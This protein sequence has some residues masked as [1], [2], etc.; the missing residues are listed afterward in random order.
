MGALACDERKPK[1]SRCVDRNLTCEYPKS[2]RSR[3]SGSSPSQSDSF[4]SRLQSLTVPSP[5]YAHSNY[6]STSSISPCI[7]P[8]PP[9]LDLDLDLDLDLLQA[10]SQ[11]AST[12]NAVELELLS[13]YLTHTARA[14]AFDKQD[15]Y[16]LQVGFP[17]LAFRSKPV[18]S[19]ILALA[20][21]CKCHDMIMQPATRYQ[22]K[23]QIR[24]LLALADQHH[25][26][27]LRQ[28]QAEIPYADSYDHVVANAPLMVLY[29]SASHGVRIRLSRMAAE[30][31]G[32][33]TDFALTQSQWMSLIRAAHLA[34][35]G[36]RN[37]QKG[38][39]ITLEP[40]ESPLITSI[41]SNNDH[42]VDVRDPLGED[43]P[44]PQTKRLLLPI[45]SATSSSAL[46]K[47]RSRV[48]MIEAIEDMSFSSS[49]GTFDEFMGEAQP[50]SPDIRACLDA[51]EALSNIMDDVFS[52]GRR[53]SSPITDPCSPDSNFPPS[54]QLSQVSPWLR[55][56]LARVTFATPPKPWRR[57][58][59]WFLNQAPA[60]FLDL[61]QGTLDHI[62]SSTGNQ[63]LEGVYGE[64]Q[65]FSVV[66][67]VAMDI[68][69]HWLV[70]V[71]LLDGVWW[72]DE[73]GVWELG[74]TVDFMSSPRWHD[75]IG[76]KEEGWWPRSMYNIAK[77]IKIH[78]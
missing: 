37:S 11:Q 56:Y 66:H 69:A 7:S 22:D 39:E 36:L 72:I 3:P 5:N 62:H 33:S 77:E 28:T 26:E 18:M 10:S 54:S 68:F 74:R 31:D 20:A 9:S 67:Q 48:Q 76:T 73:T 34:Y 70:L 57:T 47:L 41:L 44:T 60:R 38:A 45:I 43:G 75:G 65:G 40:P 46:E 58:I 30:G 1:C 49:D 55:K 15:L 71:M 78:V 32:P 19:S 14:I 61:V 23:R 29:A 52:T 64:S 12:L 6:G 25:R 63:D 16:A 4:G 59:M 27:A 21:V 42:P 24:R 35:T 8:I 2:P 51:L 17:N 50:Y 53:S 13:H